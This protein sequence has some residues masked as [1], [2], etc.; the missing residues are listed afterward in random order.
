ME[1]KKRQRGKKEE[2]RVSGSRGEEIRELA[3]NS[4]FSQNKGF[5][6]SIATY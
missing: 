6:P 5:T 4:I 1:G 2:R 3:I